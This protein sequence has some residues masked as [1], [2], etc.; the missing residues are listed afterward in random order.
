M[1]VDRRGLVVLVAATAAIVSWLSSPAV[2]ALL[3]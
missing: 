1:Q 2:A 3:P